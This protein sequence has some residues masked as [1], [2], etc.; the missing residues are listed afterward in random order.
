M[1]DQSHQDAR[2]V[3]CGMD[4]DIHW[5]SV[6]PSSGLD[7]LTTEGVWERDGDSVLVRSKDS[8]ASLTFGEES[9]EDCELDVHLTPLEGGNAQ[10]VVRSSYM[11]AYVVDLMLG[12]QVVQ[13]AR[14]RSH[15]FDRLS[16]VDFPLQHGQEYQLR[17]AARGAS[18][19]SYINGRLVNQTTDFEMKR[20]KLGLFAWHSVTRYRAPR[21]RLL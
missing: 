1:E 21:Y 10:V 13:I 20:G 3:I 11:G 19:T 5:R 4:G 7:G 16:V 17:V 2:D 6:L 18:I 15:T 8:T 9:W 14:T 12:W